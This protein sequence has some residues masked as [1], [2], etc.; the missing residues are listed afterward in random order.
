MFHIA[1]QELPEL[2]RA[3][4]IVL[5]QLNKGATTYDERI[6]VDGIPIAHVSGNALEGGILIF[7]L[8]INKL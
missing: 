2:K 4:S 1:D 3:V 5:D 7:I 8:P 6:I